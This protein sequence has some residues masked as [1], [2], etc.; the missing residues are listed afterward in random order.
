VA[1]P[2]AYGV[3][4]MLNLVSLWWIHEPDRPADVL[5]GQLADLLWP[6]LSGQ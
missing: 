3:I 1:T 4:G 2:W 5:A 6:G